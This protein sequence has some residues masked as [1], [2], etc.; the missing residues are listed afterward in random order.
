[1]KATTAGYIGLA[2]TFVK[3]T[4]PKNIAQKFLADLS[5]LPTRPGGGG[6]QPRGATPSG[7]IFSL[8]PG[9]G[10]AVAGTVPSQGVHG[11][12]CLRPSQRSMGAEADRLA[13]R[14]RCFS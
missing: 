11:H 2:A 10:Q 6:R 4:I 13:M 12:D 14:S 5:T 3:C 9:R 7:P 1:M 8:L